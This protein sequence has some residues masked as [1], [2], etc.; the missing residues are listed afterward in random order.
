M[1]KQCIYIQL[2]SEFLIERNNHMHFKLT[3]EVKVQ[4]GVILYRIQATKDLPNRVKKGELGGFVQ[5]L[6]NLS[7]N[8][9]VY[10]G[11]QVSGN[12]KVYGNA[13]IYGNAEISDNAQVSGNAK[14]YG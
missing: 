5:K 11:A 2:K 3:N 6:D 10:E 4:L 7:D 9:W 12:A 13:Q 8:A 1:L 14:V